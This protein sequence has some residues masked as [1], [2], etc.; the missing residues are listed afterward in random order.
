MDGDR[1]MD[2]QSICRD[3]N[4]RRQAEEALRES[5]EKFRQ[6]ADTIHDAIMLIAPG[7]PY[8]FIYVSPAYERVFGRKTSELFED[9]TSWLSCIHEEDRDRAATFFDKFVQNW[10]R[11]K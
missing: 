4:A 9:P 10:A 7:S 1:V 3:I 2:F 6:L 5:E 11:F 8:R